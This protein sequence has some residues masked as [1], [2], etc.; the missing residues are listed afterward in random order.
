MI[1]VHNARSLGM[2]TSEFTEK[3]CVRSVV[4]MLGDVYLNSH[5]LLC[6]LN[7]LRFMALCVGL[8]LCF[9]QKR[10]VVLGHVRDRSYKKSGRCMGLNV[11]QR[12][13]WVAAT[14]ELAAPQPLL[15]CLRR[16]N[17]IQITG[18]IVM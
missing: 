14:A 15:F 8:R 5:L 17:C 9:T 4:I 18:F 1:E 11:T 10:C 2:A 16:A 6:K 13:F 12:S 7:V 3:S